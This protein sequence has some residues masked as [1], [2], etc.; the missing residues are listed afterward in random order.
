MSKYTY[1]FCLKNFS[2]KY[3]NNIDQNTKLICQD[4]K[5][6]LKEIIKNI[7]INKKFI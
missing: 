2:Q 1:E 3:H 4:N 7:I 6:K 5:E